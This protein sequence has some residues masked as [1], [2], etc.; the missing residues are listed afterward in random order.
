MK[1]A[2]KRKVKTIS[3]T[4]IKSEPAKQFTEL[5]K[6]TRKQ[7][8]FV[9]ELKNNPKQSA[10]Q[11]V[12]KTYNVTTNHSA[13][14]IAHENL[15]KPEIVSHL[16]AYKDI[17]ENTLTNTIIQYQNSD[18]IKQRTLSVDTAKYVHDKI[19]GKSKQIT[20]NTN[21]NVSIEMLLNN[22]DKI[23]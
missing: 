22:L 4:P 11:A 21:L 14:Q 15:R 9:N 6:L 19:F 23:E 16:D 3:A 1:T 13:E 8:A 10:T 20:E 12:L 18:N 7:Q 5:P 17:V 2:T